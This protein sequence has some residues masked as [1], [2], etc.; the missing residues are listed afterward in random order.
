MTNQINAISDNFKKTQQ[1]T[2]EAWLNY[3]ANIVLH[4]NRINLLTISPCV[5]KDPY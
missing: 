1:F 3:L 5:Q 2:I 4:P